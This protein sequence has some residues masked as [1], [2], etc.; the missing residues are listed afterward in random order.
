MFYLPRKYVSCSSLSA[1]VQVSLFSFVAVTVTSILANSKKLKKRER[2]YALCTLSPYTILHPF[3][4]HSLLLK[5]RGLYSKRRDPPSLQTPL[6][7][8]NLY[9]RFE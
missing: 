1:S 5:L 4:D 9:P 6:F 8:L 7:F 3:K 2:L